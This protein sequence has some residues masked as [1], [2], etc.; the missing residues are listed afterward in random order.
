MKGFEQSTESAALAK[1]VYFC[2]LDH[3]LLAKAKLSSMR[4]EKSSLYFG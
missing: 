4:C 2:I 3:L 1:N